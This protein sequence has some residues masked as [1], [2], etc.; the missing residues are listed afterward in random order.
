MLLPSTFLILLLSIFIYTHKKHTFSSVIGQ[1]Y[2]HHDKKRVFGNG[3]LN[4]QC[5]CPQVRSA[6]FTV[7]IQAL[8]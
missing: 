6:A 5:L 2:T 8:A 3:S 7:Q 1:V 4:F